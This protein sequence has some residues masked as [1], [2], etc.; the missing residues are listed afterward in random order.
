MDIVPLYE[1]AAAL[2]SKEGF[3]QEQALAL[4]KAGR[5]LLTLKQKSKSG[6]EVSHAR[7][8][9]VRAI[10]TYEIYG[11]MLKVEQLQ[12]LLAIQLTETTL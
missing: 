7:A 6:F 1:A 4:E 2:A 5:Y 3:L 8:L 11:A 10:E 12:K 9:F